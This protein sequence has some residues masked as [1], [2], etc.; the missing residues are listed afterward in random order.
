MARVGASHLRPLLAGASAR[1]PR[2]SLRAR[3][4]PH[5]LPIGHSR[6][7]RVAD[8]A[9]RQQPLGYAGALAR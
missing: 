2:A 8:R 4:P 1:P 9:L 3:Q 5:G 7:T 6:P